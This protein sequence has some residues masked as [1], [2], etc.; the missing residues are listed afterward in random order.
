MLAKN[1]LVLVRIPRE[2]V[3]ITELF[4]TVDEIVPEQWHY[5][6][7]GWVVHMV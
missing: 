4:Y 1:E 3:N 7:H 6:L 5:G 2:M